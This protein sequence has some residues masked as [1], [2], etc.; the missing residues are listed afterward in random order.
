[1]AAEH[2]AQIYWLLFKR[3]KRKKK[4]EIRFQFAM[5]T[6]ASQYA[7]KTLNAYYRRVGTCEVHH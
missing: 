2:M 4:K 6:Y 5:E 1:M 3:R 7:C